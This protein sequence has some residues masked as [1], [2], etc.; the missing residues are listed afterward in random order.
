MTNEEILDRLRRLV[1]WLGEDLQE[2][3]TDLLD[4]L[5][6]RL[7]NE[8]YTMNF[9][10]TGSAP[11]LAAAIGKIITDNASAAD[12]EQLRNDLVVSLSRTGE[13]PK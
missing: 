9:A 3:A 7:G 10:V 2:Q 11:I 1:T 8:V 5:R 13:E 4:E 12:L 6:D